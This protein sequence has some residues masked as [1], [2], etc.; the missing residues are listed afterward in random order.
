MMMEHGGGDGDEAMHGDDD[1][2]EVKQNVKPAMKHRGGTWQCG[3]GVERGT[4][5]MEHVSVTGQYV[6]AQY[7]TA[8]YVTA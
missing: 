6:T 1:K 5:G 4:D 8:Q 3:D 7:V 2:D